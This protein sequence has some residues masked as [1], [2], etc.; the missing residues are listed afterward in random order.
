MLDK[1]ISVAGKISS[2]A[3]VYT[4]WTICQL[5]PLLSSRP[6]PLLAS[7]TADAA[8]LVLSVDF[9]ESSWLCWWV[10]AIFTGHFFAPLDHKINPKSNEFQWP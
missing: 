7:S 2:Q 9:L 10:L 8:F 6:S 1:L 4:G 3:D 5:F